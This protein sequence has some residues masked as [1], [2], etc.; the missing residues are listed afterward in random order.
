[1]NRRWLVAAIAIAT[2]LLV[3]NETVFVVG[4][5]R[6]AVVTS[7]GRPLRVINGS[8]THE[9]GPQFKIPFLQQAAVLDRR[10]MALE[11]PAAEV[12]SADGRPLEI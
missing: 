11:T 7:F 6:Q 3:L 8:G 12:T 5:G 2:A 1:M 9:A 10:E 4:E